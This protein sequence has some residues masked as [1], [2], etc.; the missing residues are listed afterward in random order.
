MASEEQI[1][2]AMGQM[3]CATAQMKLSRILEA[4][5]ELAQRFEAESE[6]L[7]T[8]LGNV[9]Q[10]PAERLAGYKEA[11]GDEMFTQLASNPNLQNMIDEHWQQVAKNNFNQMVNAMFAV[12]EGHEDIS[13]D[14]VHNALV[15]MMGMAE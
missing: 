7:A 2:A 15:G 12:V 1:R 13:R 11:V 4:D 3:A 10:T 6:R 5:D 8:E 14:D 9:P